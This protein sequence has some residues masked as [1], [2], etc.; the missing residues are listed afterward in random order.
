MDQLRLQ[1]ALYKLEHGH[2]NGRWTPMREHHDSSEHDAERAWDRGRRIFR[3]DCGEEVAV[4]IEPDSEAEADR[5][6]R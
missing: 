6:I 1:G 2:G 4:N 5:S 3:C